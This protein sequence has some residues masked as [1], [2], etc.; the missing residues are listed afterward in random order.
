M[1]QLESGNLKFNLLDAFTDGPPQSISSASFTLIMSD[2]ETATFG[3][4]KDDSDSLSTDSEKL[5]EILLKRLILNSFNG[6]LIAS[7]TEARK[8]T[9]FE[10]YKDDGMI[11]FTVA[12]NCEPNRMQSFPIKREEGQSVIPINRLNPSSA[13]W[14]A[15]KTLHILSKE[16]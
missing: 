16:S 7:K 11:L 15:Q 8:N 5:T 4:G 13:A 2:T 10:L 14:M 3:V 1:T 12:I 9:L 6:F